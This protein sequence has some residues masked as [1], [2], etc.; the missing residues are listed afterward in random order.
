[1]AI[2]FA[3]NKD[4]DEKSAIVLCESMIIK[5]MIGWMTDTI[6]DMINFFFNYTKLNKLY[7]NNEL[8][9][10]L[11]TTQLVFIINQSLRSGC[12]TNQLK[13]EMW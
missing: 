11:T 3:C 2:L 12:Y 10:L 13:I 6:L 4:H 7:S 1:M 8:N 9:N 5:E